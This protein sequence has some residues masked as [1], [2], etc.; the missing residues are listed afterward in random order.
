MEKIMEIKTTLNKPA[1]ERDKEMPSYMGVKGSGVK[2]GAQFLESLRDDRVIFYKGERVKDVTT[3][4]VFSKMAHKI[5]ETYDK[6]HDADYQGRMSFVDE[7]GVRCSNS[8]LAPDT[9]EKLEARRSNTEVWVKDA[10]GMLGRLPDFVASMTVGIYDIR[11]ELAE[12]NPDLGNNAENYLKYARQ[13][14]LCLSHGLHDP[15]MDKSLRPAEDPDRCVRVV[16]ERDDG[17]IVRGAR[18]NTFGLFSNEIMICPTYGFKEEE[19]EFAIWFTVPCDAPG[20]SQIAREGYG[21]RN[22]LDHP[23]SAVYDEVDSLIVFDDVFIPWERVFLYRE[24]LKANQL[25][26]SRVMHWAS[27]AGGSLTILRMQVLCAIAEMLAKT[28][29]VIKRPEV[30]AKLGEM[31]TFTGAINSSFELATIKAVKTPAGNYKPALSPERR[32]LTTMVSE[33]FIELVEHIGTSSLIFLPTAEDW[34][35]PEIKEYLDVYMRGKDSSPLDRHKL[36]K[37]AWDLTGDGFGSRQQMYERLHSGDPNVMVANAWRNT[38]LS[39]ARKLI[40]EFLNL[41]GD[42]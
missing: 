21:G 38:D 1:T 3:H 14:D 6:Q 17:I 39:H 37:F 25:F 16:K 22:P 15:C 19:K 11:H 12:L 7:D 13:N 26:R 27:F 5:A 32:S 36:C 30:V 41:E 29:G 2:N 40:S 31:C 23:A 24:P 18:F 42:Y 4:P 28:S 10:M 34:D 20:L 8:Y 9:T 35:N 33:R